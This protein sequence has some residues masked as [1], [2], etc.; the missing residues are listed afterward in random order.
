MLLY[1]LR[2]F[3]FLYLL[4]DV[5]SHASVGVQSFIDEAGLSSNKGDIPSSY[6]PPFF[7]EG[8]IWEVVHVFTFHIHS[9]IHPKNKIGWPQ[10]RIKSYHLR[11][12]GCKTRDP[13][14]QDATAKTSCRHKGKKGDAF[15]G[16]KPHWL[17]G[18]GLKYFSFSPKIGEVFQFD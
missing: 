16:V 15:V 14:P 1:H 3:H 10:E 6:I 9:P 5:R 2:C 7:W 11:E 4:R 8:E 12:I 18:G 17:L 13:G